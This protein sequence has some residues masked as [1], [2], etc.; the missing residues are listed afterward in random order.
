M[1]NRFVLFLKM[2]DII[3]RKEKHLFKWGIVVTVVTLRANY[4]SSAKKS[5]TAADTRGMHYP[6]VY[7][8]S[9]IIISR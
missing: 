6:V 7:L 8:F 5:P 1:F 4:K 3:P 2:C 9:V